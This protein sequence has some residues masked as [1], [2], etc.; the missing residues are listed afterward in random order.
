MGKN[1]YIGNKEWRL[2]THQNS[3]SGKILTLLLAGALTFGGLAVAKLSHDN[4]DLHKRQVIETVGLT[5][6]T[7][8]TPVLQYIE[9]AGFKID[10]LR[11]AVLN[12]ENTHT[13]NDIRKLVN[14][15]PLLINAYL[16][17]LKNEVLQEA[18]KQIDLSKVKITDEDT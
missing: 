5:P 1:S 12:Y 13:E 7:L 17:V 9:K 11:Q 14:N 16:A 10:S 4:Q 2:S 3:K 18:N 8:P 6:V 15:A